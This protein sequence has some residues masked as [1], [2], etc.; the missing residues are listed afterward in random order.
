[1]WKVSRNNRKKKE[2]KKKATLMPY[3]FQPAERWKCATYL[4]PLHKSGGAP[5]VRI[6]SSVRLRRDAH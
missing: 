3:L 4:M 1:M 5:W 6:A 2:S